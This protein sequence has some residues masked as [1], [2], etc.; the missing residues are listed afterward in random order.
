MVMLLFSASGKN[1]RQPSDGSAFE[2][3]RQTFFL[4][5]DSSAVNGITFL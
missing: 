3:Q 2:K 1:H 5:T 4:S